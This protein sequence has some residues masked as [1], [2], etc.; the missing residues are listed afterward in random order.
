MS[1]DNRLV[2]WLF[3]KSRSCNA[4]GITP[5]IISQSQPKMTTEWVPDAGA[6][7]QLLELL[8]NTGSADNRVQAQVNQVLAKAHAK[9]ATLFLVP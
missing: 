8:H 5:E 9:D 4:V 1:I 3:E 2:G 6:L 7:S